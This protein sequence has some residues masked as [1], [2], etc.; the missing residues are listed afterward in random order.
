MQIEQR[1][2]QCP[3]VLYSYSLGGAT[4]TQQHFLA[5]QV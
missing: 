3:H 5:Q 4:S 1:N 2:T